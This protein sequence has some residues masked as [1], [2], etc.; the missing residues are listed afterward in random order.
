LAGLRVA[1]L[2]ALTWLPLAIL[3]LAGGGSLIAFLQDIQAQVR[4]LVT[5]PLMIL[6]ELPV[7]RRLSE[8]AERFVSEGLVDASGRP[9]FDRAV[10][11]N[12]RLRDG[13]AEFWLMFLILVSR[14]KLWHFPLSLGVRDWY[15]ADS[16]LTAA[17]W[18]YVLVSIPL[19]QFILLRWVWRLAIWSRFLWSV[20]RLPLRLVAAHPDQAGGL[21]FLGTGVQS[22]SL[23]IFSQSALLSAVISPR[24]IAAG[25]FDVPVQRSV[26][27]ILL[28]G[29]AVVLVPLLFFT[30]R[31]VYARLAGRRAYS[32]LSNR[33]I[34]DF[35]ARWIGAGSGRELP[36]SSDLQGLASLGDEFDLVRRSRPVPFGVDTIGPLLLAAALPWLP[37]A[38]LAGQSLDILKGL[39]KTL[40]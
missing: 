25:T 26:W 40:L 28:A 35:N 18:W 34:R 33:W 17:G 31:L 9:A 13:P 12:S 37:A 3:V 11:E 24:L 38:V 32:E 19:Y 36:S 16:V 5:L 14:Y 20:S 6:A 4:L 15:A 8:A 29:L 27:V 10:A 22:F 39:L 21:G 2:A 1:L 30:P 23:L 7:E